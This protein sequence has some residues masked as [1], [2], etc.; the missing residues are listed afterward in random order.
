MDDFLV[1]QISVLRKLINDYRQ[2]EVGL[3]TLIQRIEGIN[4]ALGNE[5]WSDSVFPIVLSLEQVN[6][7]IVEARRGLTAA[8]SA[9]VESSLLELEARIKSFESE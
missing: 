3:N 2:K 5:A 1:R 8:E 6:A 9:E 7:A 4:S